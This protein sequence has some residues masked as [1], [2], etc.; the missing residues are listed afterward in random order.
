[1][2][3]STAA[4]LTLSLVTAWQ[5]AVSRAASEP[6][7]RHVT[8]VFVD[9]LLVSSPTGLQ[10]V[11]TR[12]ALPQTTDQQT[13]ASLEL[14]PQPESVSYEGEGREVAYWEPGDM[15]PGD[16]L[17][18]RWTCDAVLHPTRDGMPEDEVGA[19]A[20]VP[21]EVADRYLTDSSLYALQSEAVR[22]A[23]A[24]AVTD[25]KSI[26]DLLSQLMRH[27]I[28]TLE[29]VSDG[30]WDSADVVLE[31]GTGSA[32]EYGFVTV[33]LCRLWGV[34]ARLAG[35]VRCVEGDG[36]Y[37]DRVWHRWVQVFVPGLGWRDLDPV[38]A[39]RLG[40]TPTTFGGAP[41]DVLTVSVG[42]SQDS[43]LGSHYMS[44]HT[45]NGPDDAAAILRRAWSFAD[46]P[47]EV[48]EATRELSSR[49]GSAVSGEQRLHA[50]LTAR[51]IG[52]PFVLPWVEG[53]LYHPDVRVEA[54]KVF[55]DI[56]GGRALLP[57]I[58]CLGRSGDTE[59]DD[60][61]GALLGEAA[62]EGHG[63]DREAWEAWLATEAGQAVRRGRRGDR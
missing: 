45:W 17:V 63:G 16:S 19:L 21:Q 34:P 11:S 60:A 33:A 55:I 50:L 47:A 12:A 4:L 22:A 40:L 32:S 52:H 7:G 27:V 24:R 31:R 41:A 56:G 13:V 18:V 38:R 1:L 30:R 25:P 51:E 43:L 49:V 6:E 44:W 37:V 10:G 28:E 48:R 39:E 36:F 53:L 15:E 42:G 5:P 57:L 14:I 62:G 58:D 29:Y 54:A 59:G 8:V 26:R 20:D 3:I 23:S 46:V 35:G 9:R 2:V 61:I